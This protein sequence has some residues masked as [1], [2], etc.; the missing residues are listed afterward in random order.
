MKQKAIRIRT[1]VY[2]KTFRNLGKK[3]VIIIKKQMGEESTS[4]CKIKKG[5]S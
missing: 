4:L 3:T 2:E 1:D 5:F